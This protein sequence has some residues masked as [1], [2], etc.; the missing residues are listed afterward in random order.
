M[1]TVDPPDLPLWQTVRHLYPL[2]RAQSRLVLVGLACALALTGLTLTIPFLVQRTID[3][4]IDGPDRS[5][6]GPNLVAI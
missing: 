2:W 5:R 6:L 4:A 1:N 3:V